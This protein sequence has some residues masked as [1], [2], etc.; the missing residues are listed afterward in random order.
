MLPKRQLDLGERCCMTC[1][2]EP[3]DLEK[4]YPCC[5]CYELSGWEPKEGSPNE[6]P[7][8]DSQCHQN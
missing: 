5:E 8:E 4:D 7:Q 2:F 3:L 6:E 1:R